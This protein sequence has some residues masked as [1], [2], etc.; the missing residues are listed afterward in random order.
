MIGKVSGSVALAAGLV[1]VGLATGLL[2]IELAERLHVMKTRDRAWRRMR[3]FTGVGWK[4]GDEDGGRAR[5]RDGDDR[6][7]EPDGPGGLVARIFPVSVGRVR[8]RSPIEAQLAEM[9]DVVCLAMEGGMQFDAAFAMYADGFDGELAMVCRP[10]SRMLRNGVAERDAILSDLADHVDSRPFS[11]FVETVLRSL[12]Y[13]S[14]LTPALRLL[15]AET[16]RSCRADREEAVAKAPTKM[17][18][19]TGVLILPAM[20]ILIVGPF[21]LEIIGQMG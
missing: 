8:M 13:G 18:I 17:L 21:A 1:L 3:G 11:R 16:R 5:S 6:S 20:M 14:N 15:S 9:I 7:R 19:P 2:A 12:R 4:D 10:A